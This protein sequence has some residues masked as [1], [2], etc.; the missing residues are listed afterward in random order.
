MGSH[1]G[2]RYTGYRQRIVWLF[3][4]FCR[5]RMFGLK[6]NICRRGAADITFDECCFVSVLF[7]YSSEYHI[8]SK[9]GFVYKSII[10]TPKP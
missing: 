6:M 7:I 2:G 4:L 9:N 1:S 3:L 5:A 8:Y 10:Y